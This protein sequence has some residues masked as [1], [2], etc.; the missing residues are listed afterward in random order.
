LRTPTE[1]LALTWRDVD[2]EHGRFIIRSSKTEHHADG[3]V[4]IVPM[5]P[6]LVEHFQRVFDL[7]EPGEQ[8]VITRYRNPAANLRT[9]LVRYIEAAGLKAWPKPWQ[10]LRASRA[11]ELA[12][13][14]PSHVCAAW[15][16]H[17]EAIADSFYR[18]VTDEHFARASRAAAGQA[19]AMS[20]SAAQNPAQYLPVTQCIDK[21]QGEGDRDYSAEKHDVTPPYGRVHAGVLGVEGFEPPTS[22]V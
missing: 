7:A 21:Q 13:Q 22:S 20:D 12:D 8:F 4:R 3:G 5:F 14:F 9:Q 6:E 16:G 10:N 1:P 15:L 11:T 2:F 19:V 18:T 17:T